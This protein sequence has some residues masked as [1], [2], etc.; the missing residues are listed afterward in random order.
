MQ[1]RKIRIQVFTRIPVIDTA[2]NDK[3]II[4]EFDFDSVFMK[5][6]K[7]VRHKNSPDYKFIPVLIIL[8][9]YKPIKA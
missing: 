4:I 6:F 3:C 9:P 1:L 7:A 5:I 8:Y 2:C